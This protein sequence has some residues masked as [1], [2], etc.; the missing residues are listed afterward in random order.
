MTE[1]HR[2]VQEQPIDE[3]L[4]I[5]DV[6]G[7]KDGDFIVQVEGASYG[8]EAILEGDYLVVRPTDGPENDA[9]VVVIQGVE[10]SPS[11]V[12]CTTDQAPAGAQVLGLVIG[13]I[14]KV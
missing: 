6:L 8:G 1:D 13:V 9:L 7:G 3:Y 12:V 5:P 2:I 4:E 10:D 11:T 14:R